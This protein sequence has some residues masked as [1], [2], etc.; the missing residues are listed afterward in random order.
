MLSLIFKVLLALFII[1][2]V[3]KKVSAWDDGA[4]PT[5]SQ[6]VQVRNNGQ[7][8]ATPADVVEWFRNLR[9]PDHPRVSCC[10]EADAYWADSFEVDGDNYVA[11]ITDT[12]DDAPLKRPHI[13]AGTKVKVPNYKLKYDRGNPTGH[14]VIFVSPTG[15]VYCYVTPGGA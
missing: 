5:I 10:G 9:Q 8:E 1:T 13:A 3:P 7:W 11:I 4:R 14:G 15:Y 6:I 12:R 2:G